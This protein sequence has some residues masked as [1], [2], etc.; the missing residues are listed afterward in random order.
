MFEAQSYP[1]YEPVR[2]N[3]ASSPERLVAPRAGVHRDRSTANCSLVGVEPNQ[4]VA[5]EIK[6]F[7]SD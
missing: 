7:G 3:V 1:I 6:E 4:E 5:V 2:L